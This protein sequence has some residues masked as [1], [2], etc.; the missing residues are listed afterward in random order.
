LVI[1]HDTI[2]SMEEMAISKFK[3][4]CL[5]ALKRVQ[6]TRGPILVTRYGKPLAE[7]R[8]APSVTRPRRWL[9]DLKGTARIL[10]DIVSPAS[11]EH[12]WDALR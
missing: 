8:P 11:D 3:A 5:A 10:G 6:R 9:G 1:D 2:L 12:D 4:D 7:I